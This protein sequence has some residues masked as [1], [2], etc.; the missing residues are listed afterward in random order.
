MPK[1]IGGKTIGTLL[2]ATAIALVAC[3]Y[4]PELVDDANVALYELDAVREM[5]PQGPEFNQGLRQGYLDY[6]DG[7]HSGSNPLDV[8][9][10][11][12]KAVD[13]AKGYDVLPDAVDS[14][15][16]P[17]DS[18]EE[19]SAA[20]SRLLAALD[21]TGRRTAPTQAADAQV[22]FDCWLER[23]EEGGSQQQIEAC[24]GRYQDAVAN[25]ERALVAGSYVVFFAWDQDDLTPVTQSVLDQVREDVQLYRPAVVELAG[26][27]D[28]S[29][30]EA[31][32]EILSERR[33]RN[34][35]RGLLARGLPESILS[36]E[37]YGERR[38][39]IPTADGVLEP[40]NRRVEII[41]G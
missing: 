30:S 34:V 31:Y 32:N 5:E 19:L 3:S 35:G 33:A 40:Q 6:S 1:S 15:S 12:Y 25:V 23:V 41:F 8:I 27:A 28:R 22:A 29:G 26:H 14:R 21:A 10:F 9:H 38:P 16:I 20:R 24:K 17:A 37:W 13:S 4:D 39:R 36:I 2:A 7:L 11:A 18:V